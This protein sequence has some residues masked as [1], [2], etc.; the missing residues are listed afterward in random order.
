VDIMT[1]D[2]SSEE[3]FARLERVYESGHVRRLGTDF[4]RVMGRYLDASR[5]GETRVLGATDPKALLDKAREF[6]RPGAQGD[7]PEAT[8][9]TL[10]RVFLESSNH[11]HSPR[12]MGHQVSTAIPAAAIAEAMGSVANQG[13]AIFEM[14]PFSTV[15]ERA[16]VEVLGERVGWARGEFDGIVT[17]G[18]TL[19]NLTAILSARNR[20]HAGYWERGAQ[21]ARKRGEGLLPAIVTSADAHYSIARAAGILGLG[22]NQVLKAPLDERRRID[23]AG[24]KRLLEEAPS[25]GFDVF[26]LVASCCTTPTGAF[27]P[28]EP[29]ADLAEEYGLWLHVD[30]A[31][32]ASTLMSRAHRHLLQ[33]VERADSLAWD[34]HKMMYVPA[35]CTFL[36]YRRKADAFQAFRQDAPYLL[37]PEAPDETAVFDSAVRTI[38]CTKRSMGMSLMGLWAMYGPSLFEDL[39][40]ATFGATRELYEM[41]R[42]AEDFEPC[43]EPQGNIFCFRYLPEGIR[44]R[45]EATRSAFQDAVRKALVESGEYYITKTR[46]D[47]CSALRVTMMNPLS[48][49]RDLEGLL[50]ALRNRG[51][52]IIGEFRKR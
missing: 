47:G 52:E 35:L 42:A 25:R 48:R 19:A 37:N 38:E 14:G 11:L 16:L 32:G 45:D 30:G 8:F 21:A 4:V 13:M 40:D 5:G 2:R 10:A 17:H 39:I 29:L 49:T 51:N 50:T 9:G 34:A 36:L 24:L 26:C 12:Y 44:E 27:D 20:F 6:L 18:G 15:A 31:H 3:R 28:L 7:D 1:R 33:G 23:P 43:H 46:L 41:T 22:T